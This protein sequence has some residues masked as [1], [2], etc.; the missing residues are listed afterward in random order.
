MGAATV[1][2]AAAAVAAAERVPGR[3]AAAVAQSVA[4]D[5]V[6]AAAVVGLPVVATVGAEKAEALAVGTA[7]ASTVGVPMGSVAMAAAAKGAG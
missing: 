7:A 6:M 1:E 5:P 2:V 4:A 3:E